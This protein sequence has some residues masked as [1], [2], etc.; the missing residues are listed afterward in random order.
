MHVFYLHGFASSA[1]SSK[2]RF[3]AE[4]LAPLGLTLHTPDFNAPD[5][6]TLTVSRMLGQV[7]EAIAALPAAPVALIG[8]SLGAFVAWHAT[9][10]RAAA[11]AEPGSLV[12]L[13]ASAISHPV[14]KL[15]LLA[16]ALDFGASRMR[17]LS[18]N[19]L[20]RW[21]ATD[22]LEF[23][24]YGYGEPRVVH[25]ALYEDA[26]QYDSTRVRVDVPALVFQG[27]RDASVD[28]DRVAQFVEARPSMT[29]QMLDD[30]H[31]LLG[32]LD[33]IWRESAAF[34][35]LPPGV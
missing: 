15:I 34:L 24:H 2:A 18:E 26:R 6:S 33:R 22:Q 23:F 21:K 11:A 8:S 17:E 28:P 1:Q 25:Y 29:L 19:G 9:A 27:R 12:T 32:S 31:Q 16:P 14:E 35:G 3:F 5:F 13:R 20:A 10:R 4:R 30:D 7:D